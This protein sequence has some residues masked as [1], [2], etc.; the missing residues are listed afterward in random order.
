MIPIDKE[1]GELN[2]IILI[3]KKEKHA[4]NEDVSLNK[5]LKSRVDDPEALKLLN[6]TH[7]GKNSLNL[8]KIKLGYS[9]LCQNRL[10][11]FCFVLNLVG[12]E[13]KLIVVVCLNLLVE[14]EIRWQTEFGRVWLKKRLFVLGVVGGVVT[15]FLHESSSWVE[16]RWHTEFGRVWLSR[17]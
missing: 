11:C 10:N 3:P 1:A 9:E 17:S 16:I 7:T 12:V 15:N 13:L 14:V 4:S 2:M 8:K 6:D 5:L